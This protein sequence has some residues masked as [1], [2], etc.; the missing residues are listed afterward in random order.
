MGSQAVAKAMWLLS[1]SPLLEEDEADVGV[2][3]KGNHHVYPAEATRQNTRTRQHQDLEVDLHHTSTTQ[4]D[5]STLGLDMDDLLVQ[6]TST[7]LHDSHI[8]QHPQQRLFQ[9]LQRRTLQRGQHHSMAPHTS[10]ELTSLAQPYTD[11]TQALPVRASASHRG[12]RYAVLIRESS[13]LLPANVRPSAVLYNGDDDAALSDASLADDLM[14]A[15]ETDD[16]SGGDGARGDDT[17]LYGDQD[18]MSLYEEY[19]ADVDDDQAFVPYAWGYQPSTRSRPMG[20]DADIKA[21][22]ADGNDPTLHE[23][24]RQ[25]LQFQQQSHRH[26]SAGHTTR[27]HN[28]ARASSIL[29]RRQARRQRQWQPPPPPPRHR[30]YSNSRTRVYDSAT[31]RRERYSD[32]GDVEAVDVGVDLGA[33]VGEDADDDVDVDGDRDS[34]G[35]AVDEAREEV[36][37]VELAAIA[38][39]LAQRSSAVRAREKTIHALVDQ[40]TQRTRA[41][42]QQKQEVRAAWARVKQKA[43][44]VERQQ[45]QQ[46][47]HVEQLAAQRVQAL[48]QQQEEAAAAKTRR[49]EA[50]LQRLRTTHAQLRRTTAA[51]RDENVQ[52]QAALAE[53]QRT[54]QQR[55]QRIAALRTSMHASQHSLVDARGDAVNSRDDEVGC[56]DEGGDGEGEATDGDDVDGDD[57]HG[58]ETASGS[59]SDNEEAK[60]EPRESATNGAHYK[61]THPKK[62]GQNKDAQQHHLKQHQVRKG[63]ELA[64][65]QQLHAVTSVAR[66]CRVLLA[67]L[68]RHANV[69]ALVKTCTRLSIREWSVHHHHLNNSL[70]ASLRARAQRRSDAPSLNTRAP[71]DST[72]VVS[73][74]GDGGGGGDGDESDQ[75][76]RLL[77]ALLAIL[78]WSADAGDG[79]THGNTEEAIG[80][81]DGS[82][83]SSGAGGAST[84][85]STNSISSAAVSVV[86]FLR[87]TH[88]CVQALNASQ[89]KHAYHGSLK[90]LAAVMRTI[91]HS[92]RH[93]MQQHQLQHGS[94]STRAGGTSASLATSALTGAGRDARARV[95]GLSRSH[96]PLGNS[97]ALWRAHT[98]RGDGGSGDDG[99]DGDDS[100]DDAA[101]ALLLAILVQLQCTSQADA[102]VRLFN[103]LS[104][105]L[106]HFAA[107]SEFLS[108][109]GLEVMRMC[110]LVATPSTLR[111]TVDLL[112]LLCLEQAHRPA[113]AAAMSSL[114]CTRPWLRAL[115]SAVDVSLE[116]QGA[117]PD[118]HDTA[119]LEKILVICE[120]IAQRESKA[121][122]VFSGAGVTEAL[123]RLQQLYGRSHRFVGS[124]IST[125]LTCLNTTPQRTARAQDSS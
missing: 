82:R 86:P 35:D 15:G 37:R 58:G 54:A 2:T 5:I 79:R 1:N 88:W 40:L 24:L 112:L 71:L 109:Q 33:D 115:R 19:A 65:K 121:G 85:S 57:D 106:H 101:R 22:P 123:V 23:D 25:L 9:Q 30:V 118:R 32:V 114:L 72:A 117:D 74:G 6:S 63:H 91:E 39:E 70:P 108:V 38:D 98:S 4:A 41:L 14:V 67:L 83:V 21:A 68:L 45:K 90:R 17:E 56:D 102:I 76:P 44:E 43:A 92:S 29:P 55:E 73:N 53:A 119:V 36:V 49:A 69:Q 81:A 42:A 105:V 10:A 125:I 28:A 80:G 116:H 47:Q 94:A 95:R 84:S 3:A 97:S 100:G 89:H 27:D 59:G 34:H 60:R 120:H 16:T 104:A 61:T 12:D 113:N 87:M 46:Q 51:L 78:R 13:S 110:L 20:G 62:R 124:T 96:G 103:N 122:D 31:H 50:E 48:A 11:E 99:G 75:A 26:P 18:A 8:T 77:R 66:A 111:C 107:Y 52:L 93:E 64:L 7:A